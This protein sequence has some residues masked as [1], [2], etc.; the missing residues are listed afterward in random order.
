L[1]PGDLAGILKTLPY[2]TIFLA[3]VNIPSPGVFISLFVMLLLVGCSAVMSAS[4]VA[5]FSISNAEKE[6]MKDS[7]E[8]SDKNLSKM[9][10]KPKYLLSTIL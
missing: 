9:L 6:E 1:D 5:F 3:I 2:P 4:E 7:D 8:P 10:S